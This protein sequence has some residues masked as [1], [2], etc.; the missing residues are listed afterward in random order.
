[1]KL[2]IIL[3]TLHQW[4]YCDKVIANIKDVCSVEYEIITIEDKLVNEARNLWVEQAKWDYILIINDDIVIPKGCIENMITE[5]DNWYKVACPAFTKL[6]SPKIY[7]G[8]WDN[9]VWFCFMIKSEDINTCFPIP[10]ELQ[11]R[12][13]DNYIYESLWRSMAIVEPPIHHRESKTIMSDELF[14]KCKVIV[15]QDKREWLK[16]EKDLSNK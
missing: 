8:N 13:G 10:K 6:D 14:E 3:P 9:I 16:I 5:L 11:L 12:Y 7:Y 1:M 4:D 15:K 2:S